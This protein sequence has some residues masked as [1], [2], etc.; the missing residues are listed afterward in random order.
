MEMGARTHRLEDITKPSGGAITASKPG[1]EY[2]YSAVSGAASILLNQNAVFWHNTRAHQQD[3]RSGSSSKNSCRYMVAP[4]I[5]PQALAL[6]I[7]LAATIQVNL[8]R[9]AYCCRMNCSSTSSMLSSL[10]N[11]WVD[12]S[13]KCSRLIHKSVTSREVKQQSSE[14][15]RQ[16]L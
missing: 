14:L 5:S 3:Q 12:E 6:C 9:V 10:A 2:T 13:K 11:I 16:D 15:T 7:F 1:H 8:G 4:S